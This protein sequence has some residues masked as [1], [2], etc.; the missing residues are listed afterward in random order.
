MLQSLLE[1][2]LLFATLLQWWVFIWASLQ[3][4]SSKFLLRAPEMRMDLSQHW[5][6]GAMDVRVIHKPR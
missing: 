5:V 2:L 1:N 3:Y 6:M 4:L